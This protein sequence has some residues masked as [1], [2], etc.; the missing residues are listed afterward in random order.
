VS[1]KLRIHNFSLSLDGYGAGPDQDPMTPL[2]KGG[3]AL[4]QWAFECATLRKMLKATG[5]E[6]GTVE[7]DLM[8]RGID[9]IGAWILGRNMFGPV[10]GPWKDDSWKGWW[11]DDPPYHVP[12]FVLTH[13]ARDPIVMKG[14][15]TFHFVTGGVR[16]TLEKAFAA[17][18]GKDVR[19]GGGVS[20]LRQYFQ[21]KLI[22]EAH[23]A[24]SPVL[25]GKGEHLFSGLDLDALGYHC[26]ESVRSQRAAHFVL[27]KKA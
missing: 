16:E 6:S 17:A 2:G 23:F 7:D 11:G 1:A 19:V 21:E 26:A 18:K 9:G 15:T 24:V 13:H 20:T 3:L 12:V 5:G 4:H 10:R 8:K 14:G 25:L 27:A 22:D